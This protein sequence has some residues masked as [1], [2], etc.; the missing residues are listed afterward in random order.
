MTLKQVPWHGGLE[1]KV[2][3]SQNSRLREMGTATTG[4]KKATECSPFFIITQFLAMTRIQ[5]HWQGNIS[6]QT[7]LGR[8]KLNQQIF[9]KS[10]VP[11]KDRNPSL[12][13]DHTTVTEFKKNMYWISL[14]KMHS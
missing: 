10:N 7:W 8:N 5:V 13:M 3:K 6:N 11:H 9:E 1:N 2:E 14:V 4:I 12:Q